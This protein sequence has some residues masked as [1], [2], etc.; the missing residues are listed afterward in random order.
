MTTMGG[1]GG[2]LK[3]DARGTLEEGCDGVVIE[4]SLVLQDRCFFD[5]EGPMH[6]AGGKDVVQWG[7]VIPI[8]RSIT[9]EN[10]VVMVQVPK[11][12]D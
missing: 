9:C 4:K 1:W 2:G 3:R 7:R 8:L 11:N 5:G 12:L 6:V 10:S